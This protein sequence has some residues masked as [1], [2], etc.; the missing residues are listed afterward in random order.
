ME[1]I[2]Y[3]TH[4]PKCNILEKKLDSENI[5]YATVTD[6]D[7]MIEKGFKSAPILEVDGVVKTFKEAIDWLEELED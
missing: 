7:V 3:S 4:C 6:A 2:L 5:K 1:V